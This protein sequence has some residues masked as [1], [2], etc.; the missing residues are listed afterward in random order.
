MLLEQ[1]R[2]LGGFSEVRIGQRVQDDV[3]LLDC[4]RIFREGKIV[5][6]DRAGAHL[7]GLYALR[8]WLILSGCARHAFAVLHARHGVVRRCG[9]E[10][11]ADVAGYG[12]RLNARQQQQQDRPCDSTA[13]SRYCIDSRSGSANPGS[14]PGPPSPISF[15]QVFCLL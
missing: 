11:T 7:H 8:R 3:C 6:A 10:G 5:A 13:H 9:H 4:A 12:E 2:Q 15:P 14:L 1:R